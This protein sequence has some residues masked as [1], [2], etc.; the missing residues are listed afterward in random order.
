MRLTSGSTGYANSS[1]PALVSSKMDT[2]SLCLSVPQNV[3]VDWV[4]SE[5]VKAGLPEPHCPI[6]THMVY[7]LL[8]QVDP[9]QVTTSA[10]KL[11]PELLWHCS[12]DGLVYVH[13]APT[14][15]S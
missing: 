14:N 8:D 1:K 5:A 4:V 3:Q 9:P 7:S 13:V 6:L 2:S 15:P 12:R 10:S 11:R